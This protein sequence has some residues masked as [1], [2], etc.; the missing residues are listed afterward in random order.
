M[1]YLLETVGTLLHTVLAGIVPLTGRVLSLVWGGLYSGRLHGEVGTCGME[2]GQGH[3]VQ[4]DLH[5]AGIKE[6]F[7]ILFVEK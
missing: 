5:A 1:T 6:E 2:V 4:L 7:D 3:Q